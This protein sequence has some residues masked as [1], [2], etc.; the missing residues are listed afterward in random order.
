MKIKSFYLLLIAILSLIC[1]SQEIID[2]IAAIVGNQI[3]LKSDVEQLARINASQIRL[4]PEK[5]PQKYFALLDQSLNALI[6]ENLLLEQAKIETIEVKERDVENM[7]TQQIEN[8]IAQAGS[9]SN[10]EK[11]L[12]GSI[13]SIKKTYRPIIKNRLIVEK[14]RNEK[15]INVSV[16]RREVEEFY[17]T[18][19][20]SLPEIPPSYDFSQILISTKPGDQ[21]VSTARSLA[22]S[23]LSLIR[24]GADFAR[25][26]EKYSQD[27]ASVRYG[28]DLGYIER[29]GFIKKFEEV[30]F[31]LDKNEVSNVVKTDFGY[32]ILQ[33]LDRKGES[34]NV[35]HILIKP[36]LSSK[37]IEDSRKK[38]HRIRHKIINREIS[39]DSATYKFSDDPDAKINLGRI[40]RIPK[41]EIVQ[42]KFVT[43]LD[44]LKIGEISP[45][46]RT[47]M[48]FHI[49][50]LN[51]VYENSWTII[52]QWA[53]E[54]KKSKL[55]GEWI[56]QLRSQFN[57]DIKS[58]Y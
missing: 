45:V 46:F 43:V 29:G 41:N 55:Y 49:L 7:L 9:K 22:D 6:N 56:Q 28:G 16:T 32:H 14:L 33:L 15:F 50:K 21:E 4:N 37:N 53:L 19:Q 57:I 35:R 10:A 3:I 2:G 12:G 8:I 24:K 38:A 26:A 52:Q 18:Y 13:P 40:Q 47:D 27:P 44:S 25:L 1:Y 5:Q 54:Y 17:Q 34:I 30:A 48:G 39:F 11:I 51:G 42:P 58:G 31:S 23:L 36:E 20:D